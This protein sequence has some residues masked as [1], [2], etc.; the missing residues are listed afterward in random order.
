MRDS[1]PSIGDNYLRKGWYITNFSDADVIVELGVATGHTSKI[2][3]HCANKK[4]YGIDIVS[5]PVKELSEYANK[6]D[7]EYEFI[8]SSTLDAD[9][10]DCDVL[11]VDSNHTEEWVYKELVHFSP[12]VSKYIA[13][14]DTN[15]ALREGSDFFGADLAVERFLKDDSNWEIF[16]ND[17]FACGLTV[18]QRI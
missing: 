5:P 2:F 1:D 3:M 8:Q 14:H 6:M 18:L 10:I 13:I 15:P 9:P 4:V 16:Y 7:V 17:N 11:F 12:M